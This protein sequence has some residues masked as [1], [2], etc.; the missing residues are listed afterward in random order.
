VSLV[1][2]SEVGEDNQA[3]RI[4]L[5]KQKVEHHL[6]DQAISQKRNDSVA[7]ALTASFQQGTVGGQAPGEQAA[8]MAS[9]YVDKTRTRLPEF[10]RRKVKK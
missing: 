6:E 1:E 5:M 7:D 4:Y 8:D 2:G 9:R 3:V 10:F